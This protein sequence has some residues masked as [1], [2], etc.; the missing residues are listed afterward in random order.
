MLI[1]NE[2]KMGK[3][4]KFLNDSLVGPAI[5]RLKKL[6]HNNIPED[7]QDLLIDI[8][9]RAN[10]I[11]RQALNWIVNC[12]RVTRQISE[13]KAIESDYSAFWIG[14]WGIISEIEPYFE[15]FVSTLGRVGAEEYSKNTASIFKTLKT[16][17]DAAKDIKQSFN[18]QQLVVIE[19]ERVT[20]CHVFQKYF[21]IRGEIRTNG[22]YNI[23][24]KH[25]EHDVLDLAQTFRNEF[26]KAGGDERVMALAYSNIVLPKLEYLKDLVGIW[27]GNN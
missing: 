16:I 3:L 25:K 1:V 10:V 18:P 17:L 5:K 12:A 27:V 24:R 19:M 6:F 26:D 15:N 14:I 8:D 13:G 11:P 22:T 9:T 7:V 20:H 4:D 21:R 2:G 23:Q